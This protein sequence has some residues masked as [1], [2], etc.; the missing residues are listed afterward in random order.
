VV[1][2][3]KYHEKELESEA[4]L[5]GV[6]DRWRSHYN[7]KH[8]S[9]ERFNIGHIMALKP[10]RKLKGVEQKSAFQYENATDLPKAVDWRLRSAVVP[11]K[12]QGQCGSCWAFAAISAVETINAIR[13]KKLVSLSEQQLIDC[14]TDGR[15]NGCGGG[16]IYDAFTFITEK[17]GISTDESYPYIGERRPCDP[18]K[19]GHHS[20]TLHGNE[21]VPRNSEE[22]MMKAVA[23]GPVTI[24]MDSSGEDFMFYKEGVYTGP[25][26]TQLLHGMTVIGYDE[27][28]EGL[29][30]W[31]VR[32][33]WG[34]QWGESGYIRMQRGPGAPQ[35]SG[36]CGMYMQ[37]AMPRK[38]REEPNHQV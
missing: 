22:A 15:N 31:I 29:P 25:C 20:V 30:Y 27:T 7:V 33:S 16:I 38:D 14:D 34:E 37:P 5:E 2:S 28:C 6:Y 24:G 21:E 10:P 35:P 23:H 9:Q 4:G 18:K 13:T 1:E 26:G 3:F 17:G 11:I 36:M 19:F 12:E 32:N 8:R